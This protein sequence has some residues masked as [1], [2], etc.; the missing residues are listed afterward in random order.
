MDYLNS[1]SIFLEQSQQ[2]SSMNTSASPQTVQQFETALA[3]QERISGFKIPPN[4]REFL[5][6]WDGGFVEDEVAGAYVTFLC[7]GG[8]AG[9]GEG[10]ME[11]NAAESILMNHEIETYFSFE[12][13]V[14]FAMDEGGNFWAFDPGDARADGEMPVRY[15][16][17][18]TG[19]IYAQ[20]EDFSAFVLALSNHELNYRGLEEPL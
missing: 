16:D 1:F 13:L 7:I 10:L 19:D 14:L 8:Q 15:C 12:S 11:Y 20:A 9:D 5:F 6:R 3:H 17:C 4:Y 18:E 2:Q